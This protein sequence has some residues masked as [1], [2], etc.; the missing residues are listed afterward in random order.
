MK[1]LYLTVVVRFESTHEFHSKTVR[2]GRSLIPKHNKDLVPDDF[3]FL[4][5]MCNI[6]K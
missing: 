3:T 2:L 1:I 4:V 5:K 6:K